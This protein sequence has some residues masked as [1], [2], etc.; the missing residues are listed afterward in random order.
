MIVGI[1]AAVLCIVGAIMMR[2]FKKDGFWIYAGGEILPLIAGFILMGTAQ[3]TGVTSVIA[4]VGLP[5]LFIILYLMQRK[6]L[7]H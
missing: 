5:L 6:Y 3:Y 4:G 7:T 1:I 2:K